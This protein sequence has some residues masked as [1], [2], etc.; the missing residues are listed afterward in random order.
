ML[1]HSMTDYDTISTE[2]W[3]IHLPKDWN[4]SKQ[5]NSQGFYFE[6]ADGS[7]GAYLSTWCFHDDPRSAQELLEHFQEVEVRSLHEMEGY[8][9]KEITKWCSETAELSVLGADFFDQKAHYRIV[10]HLLVRLPWL[11]R[12]SFHD[13]LC[14]N[15][16]NSRKF[17]QPIIDSLEI[18]DEKGQ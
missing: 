8:A 18:H 17:F 11:V 7:K 6:S 3:T 2:T 14:T 9:W 16:A 1:P 5:P 12:A 15:H 13:Y 4:E 10:T